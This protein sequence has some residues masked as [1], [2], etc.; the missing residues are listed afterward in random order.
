[1]PNLNPPEWMIQAGDPGPAPD[2]RDYGF[3]DP[4][5]ARNVVSLRSAG[6]QA[7]VSTGLVPINPRPFT[8]RPP[9]ILPPRQWLYGHHLIRQYA[10]ATIAPGGAGKTTLTVTDALAMATGRNLIGAKPHRPL[11]V[12][13][14]N[15]EDPADEL[16]RRMI[17]AIA[18]HGIQPD[19]IGDRLYID[20]GRDTPIRIG[21]S[22]PNGPAISMPVIDGLVD[23]ITSRQI[24]VL[25]VDPFVSV[26][27]MPEN[28]NGAMDAAV[29][30]F[31][32]V[33]DRTGCA[34]DLVHHSRKLNGQ[35][36][37]I[38][39]ARGGSAIAGAVRAAR[40]LNV[41][42]K[43]TAEALGIPADERRSLVRV[44][45]AKANLAPASSARWFRLASQ[46]MGNAIDDRPEDYVAVAE[47]WTPPDAF[48]GITVADLL[49]VQHAVD[50]KALRENVQAND[51]VGYVIGPLLGLNPQDKAD[52]ARIKQLVKTWIATGALRVERL[53]DGKGNERPS[54]LIGEWAVVDD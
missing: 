23:A 46:P 17:A 9:A 5:A 10:S 41:M 4:A 40:V 43:E 12:W 20:S 50:G 1:M 31:A 47:A 21:A 49:K 11:R 34:I 25:I 19:E 7:V 45:D 36:A 48:D 15:G 6:G 51:W 39:A 27:S 18:F 16:E 44:D 2:D 30:A 22:T 28:D 35:D 42:S 33:A 29:K 54:I 52:K 37:D 3:D 8:Y 26:H 32:L 13:L 38:D 24:D 14:W 53:P